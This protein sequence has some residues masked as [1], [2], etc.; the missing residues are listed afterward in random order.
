M[1]TSL[2]L[3]PIWLAAALSCVLSSPAAAGLIANGGFES[4][5]TGWTR[6]DQAGSDGGFSLQTGLVSPINGNAVPAPP[7]GTT[8]AMTDAQGPGAHALT[9]S[10][11]VP[12]SV[13]SASLH[14]DLFIGNRGGT[15]FTPNLLDFSTPALNQQARVDILAGSAGAFSLLPADLLMNVYRTNVGDQAVSSAYAHLSFDVTSLLNAHLGQSLTLRFA[16]TDNVLTFQ[17]GVDNVDI[18]VG[19]AVPEPTTWMLVLIVLIGGFVG[20]L[21]RARPAKRVS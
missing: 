20:L 11:L 13:P 14:F 4:G 7:G 16:E 1:T 18:D 12:S 6:T 21:A 2:T 15:F 8:A 19:A 3:K 9:Q 5:F 10:F 17:L